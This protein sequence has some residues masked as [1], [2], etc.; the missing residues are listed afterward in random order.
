MLRTFYAFIVNTCIRYLVPIFIDYFTRYGT[1]FTACNY[2]N[3]LTC[4]LSFFL[5]YSGSFVIFFFVFYLVFLSRP[6]GN[7]SPQAMIF[8]IHSCRKLDI[9]CVHNQWC[10]QSVTQGKNTCEQYKHKGNTGLIGK[11]FSNIDLFCP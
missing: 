3:N 6:R 1:L 4:Y 11:Q 7:T 8:Q 10:S 9:E 2:C 5:L